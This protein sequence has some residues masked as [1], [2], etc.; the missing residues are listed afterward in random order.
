MLWEGPD[1]VEEV[2]RPAQLPEKTIG[3]KV[4][5]VPDDPE[6]SDSQNGNTSEEEEYVATT[7]VRLIDL[8]YSQLV[9]IIIA[10][11]FHPPTQLFIRL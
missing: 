7:K 11:S 9:F 6:D 4:L 2:S 10:A 5:V 8:K 3:P 1:A